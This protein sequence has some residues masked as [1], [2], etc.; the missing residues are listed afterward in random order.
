VAG[1]GIDPLPQCRAV[2]A[3]GLDEDHACHGPSGEVHRPHVRLL[4]GTGGALRAEPDHESVLDDAA[5]HVAA[6]HKRQ[7]AE[8]L[9]FG[10]G[11]TAR[12]H[13]PDPVR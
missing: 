2:Q 13:C 1:G 6:E 11:V 8:H 4:Q 3:G 12:E 7:A 5:E 9:P 10:H